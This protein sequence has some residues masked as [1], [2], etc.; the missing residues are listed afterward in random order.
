MII[1]NQQET[2][3]ML[4]HEAQPSPLPDDIDYDV[5]MFLYA[6]EMNE[7]GGAWE[8]VKAMHT[9]QIE[10]HS[11]EYQQELMKKHSL[12]FEDLDEY[13]QPI[14]P[15]LVTSK[16]FTT[17]FVMAH[18]VV[19]SIHGNDELTSFPKM[20]EMVDHAVRMR[21]FLDSPHIPTQQRMLQDFI[22]QYGRQGFAL[23]GKSSRALLS[24]WSRDIYNEDEEHLQPIYKLGFGAMINAGYT[25]QLGA[26]WTH[27]K[28]SA[29]TID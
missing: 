9:G 12:I 3:N 2:N 14:D 4:G 10:A 5:E 28:K 27:I 6:K 13:L 25:R 18:D 26:N 19:R 17:G 15:Y 23:M 29:D 16:S 11:F 21:P 1:L 24:E 20:I 7:I 8:V 22:S